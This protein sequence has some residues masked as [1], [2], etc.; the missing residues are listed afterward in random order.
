MADRTT[1]APMTATEVVA[2][3]GEGPVT[4]AETYDNYDGA[5]NAYQA[6]DDIENLAV[7]RQRDNA[8]TF[9]DG[10]LMGTDGRA[11]GATNPDAGQGP[12]TPEEDPET[13]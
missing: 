12:A 10:T 3:R 8:S 7:R 5:L 11:Y 2:Q 9:H 4:L 13:P 1:D 6:R